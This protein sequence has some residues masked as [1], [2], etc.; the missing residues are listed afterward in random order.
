[1]HG[2]GVDVVIVLG[3]A[4]G[5]ELVVALVRFLVATWFLVTGV[6]KAFAPSIGNAIADGLAVLGFLVPSL[7]LVLLMGKTMFGITPPLV[8]AFSRLEVLRI[9][10][11]AFLLLHGL[12]FLLY[13]ARSELACCD[14]KNCRHW[15]GVSDW[16][17]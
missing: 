3:L 11:I 4:L 2:I 12:V 1:M 15:A 6:L 9:F 14:E 7:L 13:S 16:R 8:T 10:T 5:L 17:L